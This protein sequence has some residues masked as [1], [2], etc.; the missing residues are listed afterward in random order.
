MMKYANVDS[1]HFKSSFQVADNNCSNR[2]NMKCT[3]NYMLR[4]YRMVVIWT[5][6]PDTT[7]LG[8]P[9]QR[10]TEYMGPN[11]TI[12]N[13]N[14]LEVPFIM[15]TGGP[16]SKKYPAISAG[17]PAHEI[18]CDDFSWL[19][20]EAKDAP[21]SLQVSRWDSEDNVANPETGY[22]ENRTV[23][24]ANGVKLTRTAIN[25]MRIDSAER[26]TGDLTS[27]DILNLRP[28]LSLTMKLNDHEICQTGLSSN[29]L[30]DAQG[31]F[32]KLLDQ[33]QN[34]IT[35]Q[36]YIQ[37]SPAMNELM[38]QS[39]VSSNYQRWV[40]EFT[41]VQNYSPLPVYE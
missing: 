35:P 1:A 13:T 28:T 8:K 6:H 24:G 14:P 3:Y 21:L 16:L 12:R 32:P 34:K 36:V 30:A 5:T 19:P 23:G 17:L 10:V 41:S 7:K 26:I 37:G 9:V 18:E 15:F 29:L 27:F 39:N 22:N 33:L 11:G 38:Q 4:F 20:G 40:M 2:Q 31:Y 25:R